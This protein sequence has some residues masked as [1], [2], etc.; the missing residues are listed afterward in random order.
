MYPGLL[1]GL[2]GV[3]SPS[4]MAIETSQKRENILTQTQCCSFTRGVLM[5]SVEQGLEDRKKEGKRGEDSEPA[6]RCITYGR[7]HH[8]EENIRDPQRIDEPRRV[9]RKKLP[10]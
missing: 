3:N 6:R 2:R 7:G 8:K 1:G 10:R 9:T 5:S 4:N